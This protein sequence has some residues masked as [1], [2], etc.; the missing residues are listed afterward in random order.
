MRMRL[1]NYCPDANNFS[2]LA[3]LIAWRAY[4]IKPTMGSGQVFRLRQ[5]PLASR[6]SSPVH[7]DDEPLPTAPINQATEGGKRF[8]CKQILSLLTS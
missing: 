2:P 4:L 1:E 8:A 7:I 6:L 5:C 3:P